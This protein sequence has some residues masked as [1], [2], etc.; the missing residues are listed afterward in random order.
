MNYKISE[1]A[2]N[3]LKR[4]Y[5][6]GVLH[7]GEAQASKYYAELSES[8]ELLAAQPELYPL[9]EHIQPGCRRCVYGSHSIYYRVQ[10][11]GVVRILRILKR[12]DLI[13]QLSRSC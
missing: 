6:W 12:E 13:K 2:K 8:I 11:N 3:D 9:I 7:H 4:L 10:N 5:K 1:K